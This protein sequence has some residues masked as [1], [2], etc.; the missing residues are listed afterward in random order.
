VL[1]SLISNKE[2][3]G[4]ALNAGLATAVGAEILEGL[5]YAPGGNPYENEGG[6]GFV[7]DPAIRSLG[8]GG[9]RVAMIGDGVNDA[10]ALARASVGIAMGGIGSDAAMESADVVLMADDLTALPYA[11]RLAQRANRVVLQNLVIAT[12]VML[13]LVTWVFV[14]PYMPIGQLKLPIAVSGHEGSKRGFGVVGNGKDIGFFLHPVLVT[15]A[16]SGPSD[17]GH[18]GGIVGLADAFVRTR[19]K[20]PP[21]GRKSREAQRKKGRPIDMRESGRWLDGLRAAERT[22]AGAAMVTVVA[23]CESDIYDLFAAPRAGHVHLLVRAAH[24]RCLEGGTR[25]FAEM[26]ASPPIAVWPI[27]VPAKPGRAERSARVAASFKRIEIKRPHYGHINKS[28]PATIAL[29]AIR[30]A[31]VDPPEGAPPIAWVLLT[32]HAVANAQ[33]VARIVGWYRAR[34]TIEQVF[35]SIKTQGFD[36]ERSQIETP[37]AMAKLAIGVLI[38]AVG[39]MQLVHARSGATGQKL[40]DALEQAAAPLVP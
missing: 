35:R 11:L 12:G 19:A 24:D 13:A 31:E 23:D 5:K 20:A 16:G 14:G 27:T 26:A 40:T 17:V 10:P 6:I 2:D 37:Q 30:V 28:R 8:E 29:T 7:P 1:K 32:T 18:C 9:R 36:L 3:L 33:D 34:W 25:L 4:E 15:E 22:L 21:G 39:T 38:A